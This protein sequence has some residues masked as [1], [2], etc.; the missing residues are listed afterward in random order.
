MLDPKI[1]E[2]FDENIF[3][4]SKGPNQDSLETFLDLA[5]QCLAESQAQRPNIGIVVEKIKNALQLQKNHKDNLQISL[6]DIKLATNDFSN[7]NHIGRGGFGR[8]DYAIWTPKLPHD[9]EEIFKMSKE[10]KK[11]LSKKKKDLHDM[12]SEGILL[13]KG[14]VLFSLGDNDEM[15]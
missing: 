10:S 3:T 2:E 13:Q 9:Y 7:N 12:L 5:Y 15:K 8:D 6:E 4:L 14:K 11:Y 1:K